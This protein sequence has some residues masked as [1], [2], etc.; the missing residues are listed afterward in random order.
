MDF[1]PVMLRLR[2]TRCLVVGDG[3]TAFRKTLTLLRYGGKVTVVSPNLSRGMQGLHKRGL[4]FWKS[5]RFRLTDL[6][7][8]R[9]VI[10]ATGEQRT[11]QTISRWA[12]RLHILINAVD[13]PGASSIIFPA[14]YAV[15]SLNIAVSTQ[16]L[17]PALARK[18]KGE[19]AKIY[20][21]EYGVYLE[22]LAQL[23]QAVQQCTPRLDQR[24][25]L[26]NYLLSLDRERIISADLN[27]IKELLQDGAFCH[28][29]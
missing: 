2:N 28:R 25:L 15:G 22:R 5:R 19:I 16:G 9:L 23:R 1:L 12:Q 17:V 29:H 3:K 18:I 4:I 6:V 26:M 24:K 7:G 11:N 20:N 21:R 8:F 27:N 10:A 13:D 14:I